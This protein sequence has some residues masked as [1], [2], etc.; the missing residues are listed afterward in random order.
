M[1]WARL[2]RHD[3]SPRPQA[4]LPRTSLGMPKQLTH[5]MWDC[6][7]GH[8]DPEIHGASADAATPDTKQLLQNCER[9]CK[10]TNCRLS[11]FRRTRFWNLLRVTQPNCQIGSSLSI[12]VSAPHH[13]LLDLQISRIIRQTE[14]GGHYWSVRPQAAASKDCHL[15]TLHGKHG[16]CTNDLQL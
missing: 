12:F 8:G 3:W 2:P 9:L 11:E 13:P 15:E 5:S 7:P 10:S 16:T 6:N 1:K 14:K 4:A